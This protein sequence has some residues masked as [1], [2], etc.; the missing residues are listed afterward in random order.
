MPE[1]NTILYVSIGTSFILVILIISILFNLVIKYKN[2]SENMDTLDKRQAFYDGNLNQFIQ[3]VNGRVDD[4]IK[5]I[6]PT[7]I[8][9]SND[10][11]TI[12]KSGTYAL[13]LPISI[14]AGKIFRISIPSF[15]IKIND[16]DAIADY[17]SI[18]FAIPPNSTNTVDI[19][20]ITGTDCKLQF[21]GKDNKLQITNTKDTN[22]YNIINYIVE[23]LN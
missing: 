8:K 1:N 14:T 2:V 10:T 20:M 9:H 11:I 21:V 6:R 13:A 7:I 12:D 5:S 22:S 19:G 16:G 3:S 4:S 23:L 18:T 17:Y 15:S